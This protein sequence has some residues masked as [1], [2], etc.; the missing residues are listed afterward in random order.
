MPFEVVGCMSD[1]VETSLG[2]LAHEM[3]EQGEN[4]S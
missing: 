3:F 1:C 4:G 2:A